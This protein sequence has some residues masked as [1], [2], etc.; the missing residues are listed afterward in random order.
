[1]AGKRRSGFTAPAA[2][3]TGPNRIDH[4]RAQSH[5]EKRSIVG[6]AMRNVMA[7]LA[8]IASMSVSA[9]A[10]TVPE[11]TLARFDCGTGQAPTDVGIRFTDTMRIAVSKSRS[12][13]HAT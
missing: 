4:I 1:L 9:S 5:Y 13:T 10:Q 8:I 11:I 7:M 6:Q 3:L 12:S 2:V